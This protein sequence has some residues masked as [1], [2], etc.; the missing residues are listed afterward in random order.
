MVR[1]Y[2]AARLLQR[3]ASTRQGGRQMPL[4]VSGKNISIGISLQQ[5]ISDRVEEATSKYFRGGYSGHATV[6]RDGFGFR[7]ECVLH[8]DSGA[9]LEAEGNAADAY[10][11]ADQAAGHIE[12]RLRRYKRRLKDNQARRGG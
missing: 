3:K 4:R 12:K 9:S 8:L 11:S 1:Q 6:G 10:D 7:T 5:R 2:T